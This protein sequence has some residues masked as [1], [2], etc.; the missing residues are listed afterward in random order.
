MFASF[1][2]KGAPFFELLLQQNELL[3]KVTAI[4][5]KSLDDIANSEA[6]HW[7]ITALEEEADEIHLAINRHLSLSFITPIDREDI[8]HINKEQEEAID[9]MYNLVNR[10][11]LFDFTHVR[12]AMHRLAHILS[13]MAAMTRPMLEGL[14]QKR[15]SHHT[16]AFRELRTEGEM[17]LG[18]GL[19]ELYDKNVPTAMDMMTILKWDHAFDRLEAVFRQVIDLA[20]TIEEAVL[21][22]V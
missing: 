17:L 6:F 15:D 9:L 8:L 11:Y 13:Q 7:D 20:E 5:A 21:K 18:M 3:C 10:I 22:N 19:V 2:P 1:L 16:R 14:S 12:F 4:F